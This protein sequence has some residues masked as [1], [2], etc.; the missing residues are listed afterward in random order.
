MVKCQHIDDMCDVSGQASTAAY[1]TDGITRHYNR[2]CGLSSST[3]RV[4]AMTSIDQLTQLLPSVRVHRAVVSASPGLRQADS[5]I[6]GLYNNAILNQV[7]ETVL[8]D[9]ALVTV[10][11]LQ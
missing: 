1:L 7:V 5:K 2:I 10:C 3:N 6:S 8:I 4:V 11:K 9:R